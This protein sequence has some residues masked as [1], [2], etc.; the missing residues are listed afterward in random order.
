MGILLWVVGALA[1][2]SGGLKLRGRVRATVGTARI[3]VWETAVGALTAVGSGVGLARER[4]LAWTAVAVTL[5]FVVVS[6]VVH[7]RRTARL[8]R[9]REESAE[10]R[11]RSHLESGP[12]ST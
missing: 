12:P 7:I 10:M 3:A 9:S 11:L 2:A 8:R 4:P 5:G 6:S 1:L